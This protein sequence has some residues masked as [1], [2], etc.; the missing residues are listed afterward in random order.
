MHRWMHGHT[1]TPGNEISPLVFG[2]LKTITPK[3]LS[4]NC[5]LSG[6]PLT[7]YSTIPPFNDPEKE[8]F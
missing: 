6:Y 5:V 4:K 8:G 7:L 3:L 2:Q 1:K